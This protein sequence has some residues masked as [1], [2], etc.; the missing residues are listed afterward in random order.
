MCVLMHYKM[1]FYGKRMKTLIS[2][3]VSSKSMAT[4]TTTTTTALQQQEHTDNNCND[5]DDDNEEQAKHEMRCER[6]TFE[7]VK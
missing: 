6:E 7:T 2:S 5:D 1:K 3:F 4:M